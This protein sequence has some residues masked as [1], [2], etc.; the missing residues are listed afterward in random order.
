MWCVA[1]LRI[2]S[3]KIAGDSA[4]VTFHQPESHIHFM[5]PWPSPMVT[6]DGHN[7]AFYL[8]NAKELLDSEGEWYLDAKAS[9]LYYIPRKGENMNTAEVIVPAVETLLK[10]EGTPDNPVKDVTFEGITFSYATWMRPSISGHAPPSGRYVH[11]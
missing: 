1:N 8:T 2:K 10:V 5:H 9:K 7:S 6:S 4:A 11:D 3:V